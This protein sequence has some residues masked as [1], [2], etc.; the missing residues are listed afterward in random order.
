MFIPKNSLAAH[1]LNYKNTTYNVDK[2][3]MAEEVPSTF[4][5]QKL[6]VI[7]VNA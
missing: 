3:H 1:Q 5:N 2:K 4:L 7:D 6:L